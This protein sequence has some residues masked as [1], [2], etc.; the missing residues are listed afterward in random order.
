[1]TNQLSNTLDVLLDNYFDEFLRGNRTLNDL[2]PEIYSKIKYNFETDLLE[3]LSIDWYENRNLIE[4]YKD[5]I[6]KWAIARNYQQTR[7]ITNFIG[8]GALTD[9]KINDF[10]VSNKSRFNSSWL[11]AENRTMLQSIEMINKFE[12]IPNDASLMYVTASDELV[13]SSHKELH[14]LVLPKNDPQWASLMPPPG[15]S[16]WNCRCTVVPTY[17]R[18]PS[19]D[20]VL[21]MERMSKI[22]KTTV[23]KM[24]TK[25]H[26]LKSGE[27][28]N[29][30]DTYFKGLPKNI[31]GLNEI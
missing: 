22:E 7:E 14:G 24:K 21:R 8:T 30:T 1:M 25:I 27:M 3:S 6:N 18:I 16:P 20:V 29:S 5:N 15:S 31:K 13:R 9:G 11:K 23:S 17:S 10:L 28:F 2:M 4:S 12:T 19:T 26:P